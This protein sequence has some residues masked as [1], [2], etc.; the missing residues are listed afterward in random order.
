MLELVGYLAKFGCSHFYTLKSQKHN[1]N[2]LYSPYRQ[3][4]K[5]K[6]TKKTKNNLTKTELK[7][8]N[9]MVSLLLYDNVNSWTVAQFIADI[10][11]I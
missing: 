2:D 4:I 3:R 1:I 8:I 5:L 7:E 11:G 6:I 9:T 10:L